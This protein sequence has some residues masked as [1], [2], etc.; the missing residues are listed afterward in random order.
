MTKEMRSFKSFEE[1][2]F[3]LKT[4]T[5][6]IFFMKRT[7]NSHTALVVARLLYS[8][9]SNMGSYNSIFKRALNVP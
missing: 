8:V 9:T 6:V 5:N 2:Q 4:P 3:P 1:K 7:A